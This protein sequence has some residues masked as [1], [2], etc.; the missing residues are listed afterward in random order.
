M[1]VTRSNHIPDKKSA[2]KDDTHKK[3]MEFSQKLGSTV[4]EVMGL[5]QM[6]KNGMRQ[7]YKNENWFLL[8]DHDAGTYELSAHFTSIYNTYLYMI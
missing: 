4:Y 5:M 1:I 7:K 3:L 6:L 2:K 8:N